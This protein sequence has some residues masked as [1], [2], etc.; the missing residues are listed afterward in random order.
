MLRTL[1]S[2]HSLNRCVGEWVA[3]DLISKMLTV[4]PAHRISIE[5]AL[6]HSWM[7]VRCFYLV[8]NEL[9][10][11]LQDPAVLA[12]VDAVL[13]KHRE[14]KAKI[15][16]AYVLRVLLFYIFFLSRVDVGPGVQQMDCHQVNGP[17][18][19]Q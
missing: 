2:V 14:S 13:A 1:F 5:D 6:A 11:R 10:L 9:I 4:D 18:L 15:E 12:R 3:Q 16:N 17:S 19:T 8:Y 7:T